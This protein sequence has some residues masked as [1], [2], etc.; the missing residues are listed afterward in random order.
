[1]PWIHVFSLNHKAPAPITN[2]PTNEAIAFFHVYLLMLVCI[3]VYVNV[4]AHVYEE[5]RGITLG[6]ILNTTLDWLANE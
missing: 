1:M 3:H 2:I 5:A 4:C 6:S